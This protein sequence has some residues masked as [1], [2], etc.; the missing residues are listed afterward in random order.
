MYYFSAFI[1]IGEMEY[2]LDAA[3]EIRMKLLKTYET[4]DVIRYTAINLTLHFILS[5]SFYLS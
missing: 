4:I 1:S 5:L 3:M 2:S